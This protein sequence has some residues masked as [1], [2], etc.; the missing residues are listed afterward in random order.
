VKRR[1]KPPA[2]ATKIVLSLRI[3]LRLRELSVFMATSVSERFFF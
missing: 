1:K 2:S 3:T